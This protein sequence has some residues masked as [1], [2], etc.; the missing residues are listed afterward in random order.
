MKTDNKKHPFWLTALAD[1]LIDPHHIYGA[2][3]FESEVFEDRVSELMLMPLDVKMARDRFL[4]ARL[5]EGNHSELS[6]ITALPDEGKQ[7]ASFIK[8]VA[9]MLR[10]KIDG[11]RVCIQREHYFEQSIPAYQYMEKMQSSDQAS[12]IA[13]PVF[14]AVYALEPIDFYLDSYGYHSGRRGDGPEVLAEARAQFLSAL[15]ASLK[16]SLFKRI[17]G[18]VRQV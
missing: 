14:A 7:L 3:Y 13:A 8:G 10:G 12:D 15:E 18:K 4:L 1:Y 9:A 6:K 5:T 11:K 2:S 16:K 17:I